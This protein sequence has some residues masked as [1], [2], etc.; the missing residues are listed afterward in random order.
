MKKD[1]R[2]DSEFAQTFAQITWKNINKGTFS[3]L[4]SADLND[5]QDMFYVRLEDKILGSIL[6]HADEDLLSV[7]E[8]VM[9]DKRSS[10]TAVASPTFDYEAFDTLFGLAMN[11]PEMRAKIEKDIMLFADDFKKTVDTYLPN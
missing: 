11:D 6:Q 10:K 5:L 2:R 7:Y 3:H 8:A 1:I 9:L 4:K